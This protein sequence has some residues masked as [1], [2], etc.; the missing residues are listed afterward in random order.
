MF[1]EFSSGE[2]RS[3]HM[4]SGPSM[5]PL[6]LQ[7][8]DTDVIAVSHTYQQN[9]DLM[10]DPE[11]TFRI[12]REKGTLESL[13]FRQDGFPRRNDEVYPE[14]GKWRPKLRSSLNRFA[15]QWF[16]NI[17]QQNYHKRE[18]VAVRNGE[19]VNLTFDP[20][21]KALEPALAVQPEPAAPEVQPYSAR[22]P[23]APAYQVGDTVYVDNRRY[24]IASIGQTHVQI[25]DTAQRYPTPRPERIGDFEQHLIRDSRN[26]EITRF[27]SA[28][29]PEVNDDLREARTGD[30][31][32]LELRDKAVIAGYI[33]AGEDNLKIAQRLADTYAGT[34]ETM[35]LLTGDQADYFADKSGFEVHIL[36][37][38]NTKVSMTWQ[39]V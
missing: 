1:P 13:S 37:K 15:Q 7:W 20:D 27:L 3:L 21:G 33:Q 34:A 5:M 14:P 25:E 10:Y 29:L 8:I 22:D 39:L 35:T 6:H 24:V 9:G 26:S 11:M 18:A 30:G 19:D 31:G 2:Y 23:L 32:L 12:D 16:K 17:S 36:D 4:E 28:Y 38:F